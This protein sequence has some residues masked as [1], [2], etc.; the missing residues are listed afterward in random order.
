M[1]LKLQVSTDVCFFFPFLSVEHKRMTF[2]REL[3]RTGYVLQ[4]SGS[5]KCLHSLHV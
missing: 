3:Y 2:A 4:I 5:G 1:C